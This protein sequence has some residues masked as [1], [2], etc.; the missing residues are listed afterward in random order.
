MKEIE[1]KK[2]ELIIKAK[3]AYLVVSIVEDEEDADSWCVGFNYEKNESITVNNLSISY[4]VPGS[5]FG[6][7][8]T[9]NEIKIVEFGDYDIDRVI[10]LL[11][12]LATQYLDNVNN[13]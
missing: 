2:T 7:Y 12:K 5:L 8:F 11:D 13:K 9:K 3:L 1:A 10:Y 4:M 6:L